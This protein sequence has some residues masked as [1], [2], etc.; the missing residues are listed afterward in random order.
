VL[1]MRKAGVNV[2]LGQ[3]ATA[4]ADDDDFFDEIRLASKLHFSPGNFRDYLSLQDVL[5]MAYRG[6]Q[7]ASLW[8]KQIG[9]LAKGAFADIVGVS[10]DR[11]HL[12]SAVQSS[13]LLPIIF[14][15]LKAEDVDWV[16]V[17]G[18][19][20]VNQ[21]ECLT[22]DEIALREDLNEQVKKGPLEGSVQSAFIS[23]LRPYI[24]QYY[25][26]QPIGKVA[27]YYIYNGEKPFNV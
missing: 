1:L 6:G 8:G 24:D 14:Q 21:G 3:D 10:L 2:A 20:V 13:G 18:Q 27:P 5:Q 26:D 11:I 22:C 17:G 9:R 12:V 7:Q 4:L 25:R 16:M 19:V 23:R 15:Q